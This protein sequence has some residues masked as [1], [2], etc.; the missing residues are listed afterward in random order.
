MTRQLAANTL[1]AGH[2]DANGALLA[3]HT[4]THTHINGPVD[5]VTS[6]KQSKPPPRPRVTYLQAGGR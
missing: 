5:D 3:R 4:H 6:V 1:T 2:R